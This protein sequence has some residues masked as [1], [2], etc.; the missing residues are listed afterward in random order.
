M[1]FFKSMIITKNKVYF[2]TRSLNLNS[3]TMVSEF[4]VGPSKFKDR[5]IYFLI[6][7]ENVVHTYTTNNISLKNCQLKNLCLQCNNRF[8]S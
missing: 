5:I 6:K 8:I 1:S 3:E 4:G 2:S 7:V